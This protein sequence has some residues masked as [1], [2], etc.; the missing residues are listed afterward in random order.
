LSE[1][2]AVHRR[3]IRKWAKRMQLGVRKENVTDPTK[4]LIYDIETPRLRGELWWSGKQFVNGNDIIDEPSIISISWKWFGE[5]KIHAANWDLKTQ[6]DK[7]MMKEFLEYYNQAEVVVG[8]N[9]DRFD[10]RFI[11]L[12]AAKHRLDV[13][14]FVRSIDIQKQAK[15]L[16]RMPSYSLKYMGAFFGIPLQKQNHEGLVMWQMIQYGTMPERIEY[17]KK[18]IAYNVGDIQ[19]TE[20]L[21]MRLM[22]FLNLHS[23]LGVLHGSPK[24]GCPMC[25][26]TEDIDLNKT[27]ATLA[28]TIQHIMKCGVDGVKYKISNTEYLKWLQGK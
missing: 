22:P 4:I 27:T 10:N 17:M 12:R 24:F 8:I 11:N 15:R 1:K 21:L 25:G 16:F 9:N 2:Y 26:E 13:N 14:T 5:D 6:D 18:M 7:E 20:G 23:H 19:A 28:G 3:T